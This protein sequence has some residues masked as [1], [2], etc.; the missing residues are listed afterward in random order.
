M[1]RLPAGGATPAPNLDDPAAA[2]IQ[3]IFWEDYGNPQD[4][5][6]SKILYAYS[7]YHNIRDGVAY[8]AVFQVFG[9]K[10]AGCRPFHGRKFTEI[11]Y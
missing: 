3:A 9:E 5:V 2:P 8:P 1:P 11:W 7:P 10:D 6:M 4:P